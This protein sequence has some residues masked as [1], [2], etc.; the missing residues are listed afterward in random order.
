MT[1]AL[2]ITMFM[3]GLYLRSKLPDGLANR[4]ILTKY[5]LRAQLLSLN[6]SWGQAAILFLS[7]SLVLMVLLHMTGLYIFKRKD[8]L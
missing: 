1:H 5:S 7:V 3:S 4:L 2:Y 8:I 6:L